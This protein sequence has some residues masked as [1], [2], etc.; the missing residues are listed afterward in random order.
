MFGKMFGKKASAAKA[1]IKKFENRDLMEAMVGGCAL[2]AFADGECE[3]EEIKK[4]DELLR[5]SKALEGFGAEISTTLNRFCERLTASY[6]AGR[7]E[8]LREIE[9]VKSDQREKEDVLIAMLTV[10]EADGE[11]E[12]SERKELDVVAQRLGMRL[13]DFL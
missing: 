4:I 8:I 12:E 10:A 2:V 9:E 11:I 5:T 7:I 13:D 1:E 6:R 3:Q